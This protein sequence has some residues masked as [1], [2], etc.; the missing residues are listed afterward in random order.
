MANSPRALAKL[1]E[2]KFASPCRL[3]SKMQSAVSE[4][5]NID[6]MGHERRI[7]MRRG[8][9]KI[10]KAEATKWLRRHL[11]ETVDPAFARGFWIAMPRSS[12][13]TVTRRGG[14]RVQSSQA[15]P[16]FAY[17]PSMNCGTAA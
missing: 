4:G 9:G 8:F 5:W 7:Q 15:R 17:L 6:M 2:D 11:R 16:P 12:R 3:S 10:A 13:F 1:G 14:V